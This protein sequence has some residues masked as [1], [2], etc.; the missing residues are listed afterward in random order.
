MELCAFTVAIAVVCKPFYQWSIDE[1]TDE[2]QSRAVAA[3]P[4][5]RVD[6]LPLHQG[7]NLLKKSIESLEHVIVT[8]SG[9]K[10]VFRTEAFLDLPAIRRGSAI[11]FSPARF[12][13]EKS[14]DELVLEIAK[15]ANFLLTRTYKVISRY[16]SISEIFGVQWL[17]Q[18]DAK[19]DEPN[20]RRKLEADI[21]V[22]QM[23]NYGRQM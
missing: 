4:N 5:F 14:R 1:L 18:L 11:I 20:K 10:D 12:D 16:T 7:S 2:L 8:V 3:D 6:M 23:N 17:L 9:N 21:G 19:V 22:K 15:T 13:A